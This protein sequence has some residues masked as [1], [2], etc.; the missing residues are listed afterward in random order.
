MLAEDVL[1]A[2]TK[3]SFFSFWGHSND[4]H[5]DLMTEI[6]SLNFT[7]NIFNVANLNLQWIILLI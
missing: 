4:E 2:A 7:T 3:C 1:E 6:K 5:N